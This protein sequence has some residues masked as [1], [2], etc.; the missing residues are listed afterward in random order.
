MT[1]VR[2]IKDSYPY[3]KGTEFIVTGGHS[4]YLGSGVPFHSGTVIANGEQRHISVDRC[5]C[6]YISPTEYTGKVLLHK[7]YLNPKS[8]YDSDFWEDY[9]NSPG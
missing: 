8:L 6:K 3:L 2:L 9:Y 7:E 1:T 5:D 4:G